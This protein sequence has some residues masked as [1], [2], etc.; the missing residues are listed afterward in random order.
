MKKIIAAILL[1]AATILSAGPTTT[2]PSV[3]V[4]WDV[5]A[6][7]SVTGYA[8]YWGVGTRNYTNSITVT[9]RTN[10]TCVIGN[11]AR[12]ATYYFAAT[13]KAGVLESDYSNEALYTTT[14]LPSLPANVR[15]TPLTP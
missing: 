1:I 5:S 14:P 8:V 3:T 13:A 6:D 15:I 10:N 12:G 11:L 7:T 2:P 4:A 9:G